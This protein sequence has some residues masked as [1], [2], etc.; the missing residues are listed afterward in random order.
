MEKIHI[1]LENCYGIRKID[2]DF[3]FS[4]FKTFVVYAP[5]GVMKTSFAK[6]FDDY[7]RNEESRDRIF[8]REPYS[9]NLVDEN[10]VE[11]KKENIFVIKSFIDTGYISDNVS[12]LLVRSDLREKYEKA[13][14][15][16]DDKKKGVIWELRSNTLSSDC[17]KEIV[18]TFTDHGDNLFEILEKLSKIV[19]MESYREYNFKYNSVFD[20]DV[21][22]KFLEKNKENLQIYHDKYFEIL[23]NSDDFFSSDGTFGT[24]QASGIADAV[25]GDA[26]FNAGHKISLKNSQIISSSR[27]LSD[28]INEKIDKVVND[29]ALRKQFDKIDKALRPKNI[30]SLRDIID[31]DKSLLLELLNLKE[32][33]K[34]YWKSQLSKIQ[35]E[36]EELNDLYSQKKKDI[37]SIIMEANNESNEWKSTIDTFKQRFVDLPFEVGV[38]NTKDSVLGLSKPE[39]SIQFIDRETGEKKMVQRDFLS[40]N[41]LSQGEKRALYLLNIIF[42]IRA[43]LIKSQNTLFIIDDIAD[44]FDYKNKYAIVEY[45]KDLSQEANFC[46]IIL[47]HNFDFFRTVQSRILT[48]GFKRSHSFIAEKN[49]G[50]IKLVEAG[51]RNVTDPFSSWRSGVNSNEKHLIACIP[52]VRNLIDFKEGKSD[53]Y[54]LLTH[55]L[56]SKV[57]NGTIKKTNDITIADIEASFR[58][59]LTGINFTF[60]DS[61]KKII[62]VIEDQILAIKKSTNMNTVVLEDKI[63]LA[64]GIRL[65]AEEYMWSQVADKKIISGSQTGKLFGRYKKQFQNDPNHKNAINTLERV[66]IMTPENIHLNSFMYEPILDMGISSL[67]KLHSE[68]LGYR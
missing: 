58:N 40:E 23:N 12:T 55:I 63:I 61:T 7:V 44:S 28:F 19:S 13:L 10:S 24:A 22:R 30:K 27:D 38:S 26:F 45:L 51:N 37:K 52:F 68:I 21:V 2:E 17:E 32:F 43:R 25:S 59:T 34:N 65:E 9:R 67:K 5:N 54:K 11:I 36:V 29:P 48:E 3:D 46:S 66:N 50:E 62:K 1:N 8:N 41:V 6:V 47:T 49:N 15:I 53:D 57:K 14:K 42:E 20:N 56:H 60:P 64:I 33:Q 35:K 4:Q 18:A 39:L 31:D 16:L